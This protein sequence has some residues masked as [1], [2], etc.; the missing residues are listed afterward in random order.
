MNLVFCLNMSACL[1]TSFSD[2]VKSVR[3]D[4]RTEA[5]ECEYNRDLDNIT[6]V[7]VTLSSVTTLR[8]TRYEN[9]L[10]SRIWFALL[11][12]HMTYQEEYPCEE[13]TCFSEL[14]EICIHSFVQTFVHIE[15]IGTVCVVYLYCVLRGSTSCNA[16]F[17]AN[18]SCV[19]TFLGAEC[20]V[21]SIMETWDA[22][23]T[24]PVVQCMNM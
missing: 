5:V 15:L 21:L 13:N 3:L 12:L 20:F 9:I 11:A 23:G 16:S 7:R 14:L 10:H 18:E 19:Q 24:N 22:T 2:Q 4:R 17:V 8:S 6:D 1:V